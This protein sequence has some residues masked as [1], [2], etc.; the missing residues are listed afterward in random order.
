M[1]ELFN[2]KFGR[3]HHGYLNDYA[4]LTSLAHYADNHP[5][6]TEVAEGDLCWLVDGGETH[7]FFKHPTLTNHLPTPDQIRDD[8]QTGKLHTLE[9]ILNPRLANLK[10]ILELKT[11]Y[12]DAQPAVEKAMNLMQAHARGRYWVDAFNPQLLAMVKQVSPTTYTSL[13]TQLGV[14]G[15]YL[16]RTT[17]ERPRVKLLDLY[18]L[19]MVDAITV[20]FQRRPSSVV[21]P[22]ESLIERIHRHVFGAGK[23]LIMGGVRNPKTFDKLQCS[24]ALA[25]YRK[26]DKARFAA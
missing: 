11:G 20:T 15:R 1:H 24:R 21:R 13:H 14:Y 18:K 5:R 17:Y 19:P 10:F 3:I 9:D 26:W 22:L 4:Q 6:Y 12:G 7:L 23:Q 25:A 8:I 16:V 2:G